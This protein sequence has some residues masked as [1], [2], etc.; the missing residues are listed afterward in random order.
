MTAHRGASDVAAL[1]DVS[2]PVADALAAGVPVVALEST[3]VTH[4]LPY[5]ANL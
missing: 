1:L 2:R 3:L 4:G 5:P